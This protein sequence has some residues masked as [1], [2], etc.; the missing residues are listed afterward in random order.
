[1]LNHLFYPLSV[2]DKFLPFKTP[3]DQRYFRALAPS[4]YFTPEMLV[5]STKSAGFR[6]GLWIDLTNTNRYYNKETIE[7]MDIAYLKLAMRGH[8]QPPTP[9]ETKA[10]V[11]ICHNFIS[12]NPLS[13]IGIHCT[14]GFNRTGFLI[15]AYL[16]EKHDYPADAAVATFAGCR[17]PGIYKADYIEELFR[18]YMD[19]EDFESLRFLPTPE[20]PAW[21]NEE[22]NAHLDDDGNRL[23][24]NDRSNG[25]E[26][27]GASNS[28]QV[29][30]K[31]S[32]FM[33]G[34][35]GVEFVS[36]PNVIHRLQKQV[37]E[38]CKSRLRGFPG[39]QPV[40]MSHENLNYLER[41]PYRVSWKADGT[42]YMMLIQKENE[43]YL[44]DR[45]FSAFKIVKGCPKF[46]RRKA[47]DEHIF[48]T[49]LDGEMVIDI[50]NGESYPRYLIYDI[51]TFERQNVGQT[52]F[53]TRTLCIEKEII[54][55]REEAKRNGRIDRSQE[56]F[57]VRKKDF[58]GLE[59]TSKLFSEK[60]NRNM[61]HEV[62]GLIFQP[63]KDPYQA[64]QCPKI[65][66]WK[67]HT[68][69][70]IDFRVR[71]VRSQNP[72][73]LPET[74]AHLTVGR[75]GVQIAKVKATKEFRENDNKIV[76]CTW[77]YEQQTWKFMRVRT[78]KR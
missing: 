14:H 73:C 50:V 39:A 4:E 10:F 15:C 55:T 3:L 24:F 32:Q 63:V 48:E 51:V 76:E 31:K 69:N 49:L 57:G 77:N 42:R 20:R 33:D 29:V 44:F 58:W 53:D 78:D 54:F 34:V 43:I 9:E 30:N 27:P 67:P 64:G 2:S 17:E 74:W 36:D 26:Q 22:A 66:K 45:D 25:D 37:Q 38:M 12:K 70:S 72:G 6:I 61:V 7:R 56:S 68:H 35:D 62:D 41:A 18:R 60:F 13:V 19:P 40:S 23:E 11:N 47:P 46:P 65:L 75:E 1:M 71:I 21:C 5:A 59:H 28:H 16:I 52:H 8:K